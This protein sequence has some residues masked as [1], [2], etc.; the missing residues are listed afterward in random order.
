MVDALRDAAWWQIAL[1]GVVLNV[2]VSATSIAL[3]SFV[4]GA[5]P[6]SAAF[7]RTEVV[8]AA[9]TT[10]VNGLVLVPAWWFWQRGSLVI[11]EPKVFASVLQFVYLA[12]FMDTALYWIHRAGHHPSVYPIVHA[13]HHAETMMNPLSLFVMHPVEAAG[14]G[15]LMTAALLTVPVSVPAIAAFGTLNVVAGTL[16]HRPLT[17]AAAG[18]ERIGGWSRFHQ[19]HHADPAVNL[20]FFAP[21]W[22]RIGGTL[23]TP[24][25]VSN[26]GAA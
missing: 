19:A 14:F 10:L 26:R 7:D 6:T 11:P 9:V 2:G 23:A 16:A 21:L 13:R 20:G 24:S 18:F 22:D 15:L 17:D 4:G 8:S 25:I 12:I 3:W 1:I 5:R